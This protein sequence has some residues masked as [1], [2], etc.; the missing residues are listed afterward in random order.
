M[1]T[2]LQHMSDQYAHLHITMLVQALLAD[3]VQLSLTLCLILFC[4]SWVPCWLVLQPSARINM[5]S[6]WPQ[7]HNVYEAVRSVER[8]RVPALLAHLV[9]FA[10]TL[11]LILFCLCW[12][13]CWLFLQAGPVMR[14][15]HKANYQGCEHADMSKVT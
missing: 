13:P 9:Q 15:S 4:L 3:L 6:T 7:T 1:Y 10:L 5:G 8:S 2:T 14:Q 11:C 12:V